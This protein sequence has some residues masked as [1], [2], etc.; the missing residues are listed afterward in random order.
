MRKSALALGLCVAMVS[1]CVSQTQ[2]APTVDTYGSSRAQFVSRDQQECR[3]L[4]LQSSGG[5]TEQ[6]ARGA[7]AGGLLGAAA[8]AAIGAASG[9]GAG[10]GAAIGAAAG[11][12][13]T[14]AVR[15]VQTNQQFQQAFN[16][17]MRNRGHSVL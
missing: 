6:A 7:V 10:R 1:G 3:Q 16:Q 11:G 14:G 5:T 9:G 8:G 15:G 12:I 4:A 2:W 17:C 13:G